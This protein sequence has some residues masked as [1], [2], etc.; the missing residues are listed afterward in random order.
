MTELKSSFSFNSANAS[1]FPRN[2]N[3][4]LINQ[5]GLYVSQSSWH[6]SILM[7][8]ILVIFFQ[9]KEITLGNQHIYCLYLFRQMKFKFVFSDIKNTN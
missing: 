3:S 7:A 1:N 8:K 6:I 5:L 4:L 2:F 9:K